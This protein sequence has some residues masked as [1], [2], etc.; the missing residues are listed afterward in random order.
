ML[1][2]FLYRFIPGNGPIAVL[3]L[4]GTG[5]DEADLLPLAIQLAPGAAILS[6]RG[7]VLEHGMARFFRRLSPGVFD[8][9]DIRAQA[10]D[11]AEWL[12]AARAQHGLGD[13]P[14]VALGLSNGANMAAALL[15]LH[16]GLF[17]GAVLFSPMPP[18]QQAPQ[19]DLRGTRV[20]IGAGRRDSMGPP[21]QV[22]RLRAVLTERRAEV[23][24]HW[25]EGGH[26]LTP[27]VVDAA[28]AWV[29]VGWPTPGSR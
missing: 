26:G 12:G 17:A 24:I 13:R 21:A 4:H 11:L 3:A 10:H 15:L 27:T 20:F 28:A 29:Q 18:L 25:H 7:R 19:A 6:V 14:L 5:G 22:E 1:D 8:E 2:A 9:D 23:D 16:P